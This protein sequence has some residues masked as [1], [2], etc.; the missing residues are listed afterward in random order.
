MRGIGVGVIAG[1]CLVERSG[2]W[3]EVKEDKEGTDDVVWGAEAEVANGKENSLKMT[4]R[5]III[6]PLGCKHL[7]PL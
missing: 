7:Y 1:F 6:L 4:F 2:I 3:L 5:E